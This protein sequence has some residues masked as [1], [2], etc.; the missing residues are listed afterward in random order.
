MEHEYT[1]QICNHAQWDEHEYIT[2]KCKIIH[3]PPKLKN[4]LTWNMN[5]NTKICCCRVYT[6]VWKQPVMQ[7]IVR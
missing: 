5:I 1:V 3:I 7:D 4:V 2:H 6:V